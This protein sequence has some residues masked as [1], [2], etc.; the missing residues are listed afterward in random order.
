MRGPLLL[1]H[2]GRINDEGNDARHNADAA[3]P[4][5]VVVLQL[6]ASCFCNISWT[7][8]VKLD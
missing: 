7:T 5:S 3:D 1:S 4:M 2:A 8:L 6:P